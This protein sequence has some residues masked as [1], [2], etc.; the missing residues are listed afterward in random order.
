MREMNG[1]KDY[2]VDWSRGGEVKGVYARL[3]HQRFARAA[4][5]FGL[6]G[7]MPPLDVTQCRV[8]SDVSG[9]GELF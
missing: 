9:L 7:P 6:D 3:L 2:D 4:A 8:P 1:G 5:R